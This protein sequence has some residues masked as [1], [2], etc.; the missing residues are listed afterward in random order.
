MKNILTWLILVTVSLLAACGGTAQTASPGGEWQL[1]TLN[2]VPTLADYPVTMDIESDQVN[3]HA[4]CN[5]Y[6]GDVIL[7]ADTLTFGPIARTEMACADQAAMTQENAF[8]AALIEV[9]GYHIDE[10][11]MLEMTDSDGVVLLTF[12]PADETVS[13]QA[14]TEPIPATVVT[15]NSEPTE[16]P[17]VQT[18]A[19]FKVY[20]DS[21]AGVE[22]YIPESWTVTSVIEGELAIL[23]SYP[24]DKYV[25]GEAR[26]LG[27][28]KCDLTIRPSGVD[29]DAHIQEVKANPSITILSEESITLLSGEPA[30]RF[31]IDS[32]GL[33]NS[34]VTE[35]NGRV[36]V[37]TCFGE[38]S[39][40]D[41][42]AITLAAAR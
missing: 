7:G 1:V 34:V 24:E 26:E 35:I 42:I 29:L 37:L 10:A 40:F 39:I 11:G 30:T 9:R 28:T 12:K 14:P 8:F 16:V 5:I 32:M 2:G 13:N 21:T 17:T 3:G 36:V 31:E 23:Q 38:L 4:G 33:S 41:E 27:D 20:R 15:N 22:V 6:S 18:P 19:G 25:G